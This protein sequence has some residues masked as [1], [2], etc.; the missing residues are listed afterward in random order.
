MLKT[1][2]ALTTLQALPGLS[3]KIKRDEVG[4]GVEMES[5]EDEQAFLQHIS[6]RYGSLY[7]HIERIVDDAWERHDGRRRLQTGSPD[8]D[9]KRA[10]L[11][12]HNKY[13]N[14]TALGN[15]PG[16]P[17][18]T[19]MNMVQ[20]DEAVAEISQAYA[21]ECV[22]EHNSNRVNDLNA[23]QGETRFEFDDYSDSL[24]ENIYYNTAGFSTATLL[25]GIE[26]FYEEYADYTY[27]TTDCSNVCG[28]YTQLVW[29]T[30]RYIGCGAT[31]CNGL[32]GATSSDA[33]FLVCN[34]FP[35]GNSGRQPYEDGDSCTNCPSDRPNCQDGLCGGC[36]ST[37]WD[38]C[39]DYYSNCADLTSA[40]PTD[41]LGNSTCTTE[42]TNTYCT[43]CKSTCK[44]CTD[45]MLTAP[46][47]CEDG[48]GRSV[49]NSDGGGDDSSATVHSV[50]V[51]FSVIV[52]SIVL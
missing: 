18:A 14:I 42:S 24:G 43:G 34:Y 22:W 10:L 48:L 46:S 28:H 52:A 35:A 26:L 19:N 25:Y 23:K 15:T 9:Q 12:I 1:V 5:D 6:S 50:M 27:S 21:E 47:S 8:D 49:Q 20:W 30:N 11:D 13:R 31:V 44:T 51:A 40:C 41:E 33:V 29:D 39:D 4:V 2:F 3:W 17:S 45:D 7:E 32:S 37:W 36:M 38:Y 16:Q